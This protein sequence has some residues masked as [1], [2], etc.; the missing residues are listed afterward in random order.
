M[1]NLRPSRH[2]VLSDPLRGHPLPVL[3]PIGG[4]TVPFP[5]CSSKARTGGTTTGM[6]VTNPAHAP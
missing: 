1:H 2:Q 6:R 5:A 4:V 3:L